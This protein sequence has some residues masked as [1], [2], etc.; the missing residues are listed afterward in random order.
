MD[1]KH[2]KIRRTDDDR[3]AIY[4]AAFWAALGLGMSEAQADACASRKAVAA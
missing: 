2:R 4:E 3:R 1:N